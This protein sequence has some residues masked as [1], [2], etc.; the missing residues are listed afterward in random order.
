MATAN[1]MVMPA[2]TLEVD[3]GEVVVSLR[4]INWFLMGIDNILG[5]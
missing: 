1:M 5:F 4:D 2:S 3:L